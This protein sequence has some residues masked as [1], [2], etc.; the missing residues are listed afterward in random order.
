MWALHELSCGPEWTSGEMMRGG[1]GDEK[2]GKWWETEG[3]GRLSE[4]EDPGFRI[5]P[6]CLSVDQAD[7]DET[8]TRSEWAQL[9]F[10]W[11]YSWGGM[12]Y[13]CCPIWFRGPS[14][15]AEH[16]QSTRRWALLLSEVSRWCERLQIIFQQEQ[17]VDQC[18]MGEKW[19]G[20]DEER[21]VHRGGER[22]VP[23][24]FCDAPD[25][26]LPGSGAKLKQLASHWSQGWR[27]PYI[28]LHPERKDGGRGEGG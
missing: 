24:L 22:P 28:T 1:G 5:V 21:G 11:T 15:G 25:L 20:G 8:W 14:S 6:H 13:L 18:S 4:D 23:S 17:S 12:W 7:L 16:P 19:G 27:G 2:G 10:T 3:E 26:D 9:T